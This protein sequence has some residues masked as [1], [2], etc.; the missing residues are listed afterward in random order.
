M[1]IKELIQWLRDNSAGVYR[2]AK[3]AADRMET[4][5]RALRQLSECEL[6]DDNFVGWDVTNRRIRN[7]TKAGLR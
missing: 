2:P 4:M 6:S 5:E 7:I 3:E 1:E